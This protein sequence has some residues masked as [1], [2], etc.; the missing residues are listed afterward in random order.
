MANVRPLNSDAESR[1]LATPYREVPYSPEGFGAGTGAAVENISATAERAGYY[2]ERQAQH[3]KAVGD[4]TQVTGMVG[5]GNQLINDLVLDPKNGYH[6]KKG[7]QALSSYDDTVK[8]L[9]DGLAKIGQ[10]VQNPEQQRAWAQ[11]AT[12][13]QQRAMGLVEG[14]AAQQGDVVAADRFTTA[15][16]A[17]TNQLALLDPLDPNTAGA[18]L[19]GL[20]SLRQLAVARAKT[21]GVDGSY[22]A[23]DGSTRSGADDFAGKYLQKG[24]QV[25]MDRALATENGAVARG[26]YQQLQPFLGDLAPH[27]AKPV[28]EAGDRQAADG[29]AIKL[30]RATTNAM[31]KPNP[32]AALGM[33]DDLFA[34]GKI[35]AEAYEHLQ[36]RLSLR[37]NEKQAA[38]TKAV[39]DGFTKAFSAAFYTDPATKLPM[40]DLNRVPTGSP[41]MPGTQQWLQAV[42][43]VKYDHLKMLTERDQKHEDAEDAP[44]ART[45]RLDALWQLATQPEKFASMTPAEFTSQFGSTLTPKAFDS[46][47]KLWTDHLAA[48]QKE[49]TKVPPA[50]LDQALTVGRQAGIFP[51]GNQPPSKWSDADARGAWDSLTQQ[52]IRE[53]D[54]FKRAN[55]VPPK[56]DD[57]AKMAVNHLV[58]VKLKGAGFFGSDKTTTALQAEQDNGGALP[59][60]A[61][62]VAVPGVPSG[63]VERIKNKLA[64][65]GKAISG[66]SILSQ[67]QFEQRRKAAQGQ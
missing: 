31:G 11:H 9:Q 62:V 43:P 14:H 3:A 41:S 67:F 61:E 6:A 52:L 19:Q 26:A 47:G 29:L 65:A 45:A 4:A 27:Y 23:A 57:L 46:F 63:D 10:T 1:P 28:Q 40:V 24:A 56:V 66:S 38:W 20:A 53:S 33:A 7:D 54:Q 39:D 13:L 17:V 49:G 15:T 32:T 18:R 2:L 21:L 59:A 55:G 12:Q 44:A 22:Q 34:K 50:V 16:S 30:D 35:S 25:I 58:G 42:D 8:A 64:A 48:N 60:N 51:G 5:Q 37:L 36:G